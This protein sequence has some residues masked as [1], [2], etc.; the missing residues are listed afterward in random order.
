MQ[1][2]ITPVPAPRQVRSDTWKPRPMVLRYR[3]FKD[4]V[5]LLNVK[6]ESGDEIVFTLPMPPSWSKKKKR[7]MDGQPH[8]QR[9]DLDNLLKALLDAIYTED[10]HIWKLTV[11]KVWGSK[12]GIEITPPKT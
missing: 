8:T 2:E 1:Y 11:S 12:G 6:V 9:P 3:A 4:H 7:E 10:C 5:R